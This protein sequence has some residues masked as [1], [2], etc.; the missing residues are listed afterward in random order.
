[1]NKETQTSYD[2]DIDQALDI[3]NS[4]R[5]NNVGPRHAKAASHVPIE[6]RTEDYQ[7]P[8][9]NQQHI[10][11]GQEDY[12]KN[13]EEKKPVSPKELIAAGLATAAT[14]GG[15]YAIGHEVAKDD[16]IE[17]YEGHGITSVVAEPGDSIWSLTEEHTERAPGVPVD[18]AVQLN[19]ELN[20]GDD[21]IGEY[22]SV[23]VYDSIDKKD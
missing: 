19:I 10:P 11:F 7:I 21:S 5:Q 12:Y 6:N 13:D 2:K 9:N 3:A 16:N 15:L 23:L 14:L 20:G 18:M 22:E 4:S 8:V 17:N 1:M